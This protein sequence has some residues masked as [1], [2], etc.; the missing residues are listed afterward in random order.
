MAFCY[1][2]NMAAPA[3]SPPTRGKAYQ[4][5]TARQTAHRPDLLTKAARDAGVTD[6][7]IHRAARLV[8]HDSPA[9]RT[10]AT[11]YIERNATRAGAARLLRS[12]VTA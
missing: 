7:E 6:E 12:E 1:P 5:E 4:G 11:D 9:V 2:N 8:C 10:W 3:A